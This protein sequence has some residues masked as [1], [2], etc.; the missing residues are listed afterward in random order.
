M[1]EEKKKTAPK[2]L[3]GGILGIVLFL[4]IGFL[5]PP[6]EGLTSLSM[7]AL[8]IFL[9][10]ICQWVSGTFSFFVTG[11][12]M[13]LAFA[14]FKCAP[15]SKVYSGFSG[16]TWW[17]MVGAMG[18]SAA[19]AKSGLMRRLAYNIM[20][21]FSPTFR[22]QV[23]GLMSV[24]IVVTPLIPSITAKTI[25]GMPIAKGV[26]SEMKFQNKS[27][28]MHGLW[29]SSFIGLTITSYM[30]VNSNFFC[31]FAY[32]LLPEDV[33]QQM[34]WGNWVIATLLWG[35]IVLGGCLLAI[36]L[37]YKPKKASTEV[38]TKEF[39]LTE[40]AKMGP[41]STDEKLIGIVFIVSVLLWATENIHSV[42]GHLVAIAALIIFLMTKKLTVNDLKTGIPW[43]M[44]LMSG[45]LMGLGSVLAEVGITDYIVILTEPLITVISNNVYLFVAVVAIMIYLVRY[46]YFGM[47]SVCAT[48]LPLLVPIAAAAGISPWVV[49]FAM[50]TAGGTFNTIYQN[51]CALQGYAAYGGEDVVDFGKLSNFSYLFMAINLVGL[52]ASIPVWRLLGLIV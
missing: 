50:L 20:K 45:S 12:T 46:V 19:L 9:W 43:D 27:S 6:P 44:L 11:M 33:Q 16:T 8:G 22:G 30:F 35:V 3:I 31:Y 38:V 34:V 4:V 48:F 41:L 26:A 18:M 14:F 21:L 28:E 25:M 17:F 10:A 37:I 47:M 15:F 24:G 13:T 39:V 51:S 23:M 2:K 5:I 42:P 49:A 32:G 40:L 52:L 7:I 36:L 1:A 29:L